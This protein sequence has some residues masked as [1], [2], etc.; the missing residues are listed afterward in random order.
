MQNTAPGEVV[1][2]FRADERDEFVICINFSSRMAAGSVEV[3]NAEKFL[4]LKIDGMPV[5]I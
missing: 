1:T 2:F 5:V 4:P 3:P